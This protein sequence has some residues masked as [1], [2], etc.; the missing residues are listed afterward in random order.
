M[1]EFGVGQSLPRTEDARLLRGEGRFTDDIAPPQAAH[2]FVLRSLYAFADIAS[3]DIADAL[4]SPGVVGI[5]T[6]DDAAADKLG[7]FPSLVRHTG[8]DGAPN[9][10]PPFAVMAQGLARYAGEPLAIVIAE[11]LNQAKDA[12][13][14]I[15]I[16]Y[17]PRDCVATIVSAEA[18]GAPVVW[19]ECPGNLCVLTDIGDPAAVDTAFAAA[20]RISE[21]D[22]VLS[23]VAVCSIEPRAALG[24]WDAA[25]G[26]YTLHAGMQS[27]HMMR[28]QLA[29]QVFA[30]PPEQI[31]VVALD[32]G[33]SFGM[34]GVPHPE[35]AL[36]LWAA[37]R[38]DRAVRW[39]AERSEGFLSDCQSR[40]QLA[41]CQLALD[42]DARFLGLRVKVRANL[43]AYLS[44][45]GVHC[46]VGNIGNLSGVY[47]IPAIHAEVRA[48]FTNTVPIGP[49]RGAGRPE[50]STML[51]RIIDKAANDI[52]MDPA[53]LR[54][55]NLIPQ[56]AMPYAT[57]F[58]FTY[59]SGDFATS[60]AKVQEIADWCGFEARRAEALGRGMLR[61]IGMSHIIEIAAPQLDEM[62]SIAIEADGTVTIGSGL[63]NHGQGQETTQRQL[64]AEFLHVP[65]ENVRIKAC[66]TD[67]QPFGLGTGGSRSAVVAGVLF[68]TIAEAVIAKAKAFAAILLEADAGTIDYRDGTFIAAG[69]NRSVGLGEVAEFAHQPARLPPGMESGLS[70]QQQIRLS[71]ST[72]PNGCHVCEVEIDPQTGQA[73]FVGYW[74]SEDVGRAI[75]PMIVEGQMHGGVVQGLGQVLGEFIE[76]DESGQL[77]TGTFMD[78][79]IPRA[80]DMPP[81]H[82]ISNNVPSPTNPLGIKG[83]GESGTV[84]ALPAGLNAICD[85]LRPL[86]IDNFHM[87]ATP[88]R[89]WAAVKASGGL[90]LHAE[91]AR[92]SA[93]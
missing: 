46:A 34:K 85:A 17:V 1:R 28:A 6:G 3:I 90:P 33:G 10:E 70:H 35:L 59:D 80:L 58:V 48:L 22:V 45:A 72:F 29:S 93:A 43:G 23:R 73:R 74:V 66:D 42:E 37:R 60:Q 81:I 38:F 63:H 12:A 26:R 8:P 14:L 36:V 31:R 84:G 89:I 68:Q 5:L 25:T 27:P 19:E 77:L 61:G 18:E 16:D 92:S 56:S 44:L 55:R 69:T 64:I 21:V 88:S 41:H 7:G 39:T 78:Y 86:G 91:L 50:A 62:G 40:D 51:E 76:Y 47:T 87:P 54:R 71:A 32:V 53:E 30:V 4:D 9:F 15:Q 11:T 82:T 57:G 79:H 52:G 49:Y 75:N 83:A 65:P 20:A 13:E 24:E 2:M 67:N